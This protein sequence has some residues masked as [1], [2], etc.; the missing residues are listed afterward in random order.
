M[1]PVARTLLYAA[2]WVAYGRADCI[3]AVSHG[4]MATWPTLDAA[5]RAEL[6]RLLDAQIV[7]TCE[8]SGRAAWA[9]L[10]EWCRARL[11]PVAE[12]P[13]ES[14]QHRR[15][16]MARGEG[17][18][19]RCHP[20]AWPGVA[21]VARNLAPSATWGS[22]YD[23]S[24]T[25]SIPG[26]EAFLSVEPSGDVVIVVGGAKWRGYATG[27][28]LREDAEAWLRAR[29]ASSMRRAAWA[30]ALLGALGWE[31]TP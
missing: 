17:C 29:S 8:A 22:D 30:A 12:W 25:V 15:E 21:T 28:F 18:D 13:C 23:G 27:P 7:S 11:G 3:D 26:G 2:R 4:W 6:A 5:D 9:S 19:C 10:A 1:G 20:A 14:C 24:A 16:A 31:V